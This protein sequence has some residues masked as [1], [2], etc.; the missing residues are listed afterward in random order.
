MTSPSTA[1]E[2]TPHVGPNRR[3]VLLAGG[4][5][6][7]GAVVAACAPS[8]SGGGQGGSPAA[9]AAGTTVKT[10]DV[11]VNGGAI[12]ENVQVVVTQPEAGT[13][14]A[15]SAVCTHEGCTVST[16]TNNT[17]VCPCH[18]AQFSASDG[19]V[20]GGPAPAPLAAVPLSVS[21]DTITLS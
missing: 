8:S 16:V 14:K 1:P 19:A 3:Q 21:G 15:F 9:S 2:P 13:Y 17:I 5:V 10:S 7:A 11:P 12:L 4:A 20:L 6:A 18:G